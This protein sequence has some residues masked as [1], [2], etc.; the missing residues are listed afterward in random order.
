MDGRTPLAAADF[1]RMLA[2]LTPGPP[3]L[4]GL[5][6]A[7]EVHLMLLVHRVTGLESG[8]YALIRDPADEPSV[9]AALDATFLWQE[10]AGCPPGLPL[11]LLLPGDVRDLARTVSCHQDIAS[12]GAFAVA[13]LARFRSALERHGA[14]Y[15]RR[16]F[17][18]TGMIG[19][20]L[21]LEAE[22]AGL[23]ATGIGCFFDD[24]VHE[25]LG[26]RDDAYQVLY[27]FTVG[28]PR[29][30]GRLATSPAYEDREG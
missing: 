18:E 1:F 10:V 13:M 23:R 4:R 25:V 8:L 28:G 12:D 5:V 19:Q 22:A 20:I 15:Y 17:W 26:V 3:W 9:R 16:L 6:Q 2:R 27:H 29:E 30:D 24:A 11:R 14:W 7:S 21:Y